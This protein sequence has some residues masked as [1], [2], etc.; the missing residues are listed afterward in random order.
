LDPGDSVAG[1]VDGERAISRESSHLRTQELAR[2]VAVIPTESIGLAPSIEFAEIVWKPLEDE[3]PEPLAIGSPFLQRVL[4]SPERPAHCVVEM[5]LPAR[6]TGP[7][8]D[9]D[10]EWDVRLTAER[11][12]TVGSRSRS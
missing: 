2:S 7:D 11:R 8:F 5:L 4:L 3:F 9:G 12:R 6:V 1:L 10:P